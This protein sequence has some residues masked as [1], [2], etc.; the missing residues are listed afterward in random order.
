[1]QLAP[2]EARLIGLGNANENGISPSE[3]WAEQ[4][5]SW[6]DSLSALAQAYADGDAQ[7]H[8]T[9][10]SFGRRDPLIPLH[11]SLERAT[12]LEIKETGGNS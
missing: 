1:M 12:L 7:V 6:R 4:I 3:D 5:D 2:T 10:S 9:K 11:R 8:E